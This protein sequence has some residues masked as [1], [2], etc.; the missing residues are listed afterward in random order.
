MI[1]QDVGLEKVMLGL[2]SK[3]SIIIRCVKFCVAS[4]VKDIN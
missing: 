1:F 4:I 2:F 3:F